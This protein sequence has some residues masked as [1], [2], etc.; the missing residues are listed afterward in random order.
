MVLAVLCLALLVSDYRVL[1]YEVKVEPGTDYVVTDYGNLGKS[2]QSS[3]VCYY[4]TGRNVLQK[5]YWYSS[6]NVMGRDSCPFLIGP[7]D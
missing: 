7:K 2:T 1:I 3:L 4:F 5:V 6:N